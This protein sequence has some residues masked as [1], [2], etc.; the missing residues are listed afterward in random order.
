MVPSVCKNKLPQAFSSL[1]VCG[2][3]QDLE[4]NNQNPQKLQTIKELKSA[5]YPPKR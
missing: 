5:P 2:S 3:L 4:L 1:N